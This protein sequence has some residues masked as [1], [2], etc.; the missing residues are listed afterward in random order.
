M[1]KYHVAIPYSSN[2]YPAGSIGDLNGM[3]Y[4][5]IPL[6]KQAGLRW[7]FNKR[8]KGPNA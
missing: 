5:E 8:M 3:N 2:K 4:A 6:P 7:L 1:A